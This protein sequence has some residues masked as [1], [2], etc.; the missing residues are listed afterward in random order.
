MG[1]LSDESAENK[2]RIVSYCVM[3]PHRRRSLI[4]IQD[5][6]DLRNLVQRTVEKR[7]FFAAILGLGGL[8]LPVHSKI[9]ATKHVCVTSS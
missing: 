7:F 2:P 4:R 1:P 6:A 9:H 8:G 5:L 3:L